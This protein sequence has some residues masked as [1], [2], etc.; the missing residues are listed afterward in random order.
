VMEGA[1][2]EYRE[3]CESNAVV[4]TAEV[5]GDRHL[6]DVELQ[7]AYHPAEAVDEDGNLFEVERKSTRFDGAVLEGGVVSLGASDGLQLQIGDE[8]SPSLDIAIESLGHIAF[9][10]T[11]R[12]RR[13]SAPDLEQLQG[14]I[15]AD[16]VTPAS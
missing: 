10:R 8:L 12:A 4:A 3:S 9:V 6:G 15:Q 14:M 7:P 16:K 5:R 2:Q 1:H 11:T 13:A